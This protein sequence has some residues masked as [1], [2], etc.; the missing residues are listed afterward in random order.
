MLYTLAIII[1]HKYTEES[2]RRR[3]GRKG[4]GKGKGGDVIV[5]IPG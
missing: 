2:E 3:K 4:G 1:Y 5:H